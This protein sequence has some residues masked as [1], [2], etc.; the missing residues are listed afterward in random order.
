MGHTGTLRHSWAGQAHVRQ[1]AV[2]FIGMCPE[3]SVVHTGIQQTQLGTEVLPSLTAD[4]MAFAAC[5]PVK[6][7]EAQRAQMRAA[8]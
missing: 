1:L 7:S 4:L 3:Q 5:L 8:N 2:Y 6:L